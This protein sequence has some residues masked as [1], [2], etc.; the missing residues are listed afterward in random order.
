VYLN[1]ALFLKN[2]KVR[3]KDIS[4]QSLDEDEYD[5]SEITP[6]NRDNAAA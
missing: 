1:F 6:M 4:P 3:S 2:E 5:I